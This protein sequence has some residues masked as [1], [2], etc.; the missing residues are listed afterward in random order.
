MALL[1]ASKRQPGEVVI[2]KLN[3]EVLQ[4]IAD[5]VMGFT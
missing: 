1:K 5:K 4:E 3:E 2:T